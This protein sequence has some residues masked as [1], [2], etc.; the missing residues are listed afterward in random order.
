MDD[1]ADLATRLQRV[2]L[3]DAG[4]LGGKLLE[5]LQPLDVV[6]EALA[7]GARARSGDRI[8]RDQEDGLHGLRLD[9][10]VVRLDR[11]DDVLRLAVAARELG[12]DRRVRALDLVGHRLAEVVQHRRPLGHLHADLGGHDARE[13][14]DLERVLE[15]ILPI[16][17]A[18]PEAP[19]DL[20]E[21]LVELTAVRLEHGLFAGLDDVLLDL[22]LG[23]VVGVL[24]PGR[25]D[26]AVFDQLRERQLRDLAPDAVEGR[27]DD[28]LRCVVDDEVDAGQVL[29]RA[30]VASLAPDDPALHVVGRELDHGD[31]RLGG[32]A[33]GDPL[34]RVRDEV[35]C[36]AFRLDARLFFHL[37]DLARQLVPD[38]VLGAL[39]QVLFRLV[40][41]HACDALELGELL[42]LCLL[43]FVLELLEVRLTIGQA[44]LAT[45]EL[46]ELPVDLLLLREDALLDLD[47]S[48]AVVGDLSVDLRAQR[49]RLLARAD[50]GL[51]T[52]RLGLPLGVVDHLAAQLSRLA[53]A[54]LSDDPDRQKDGGP[55]EEESD[56]CPECDQHA[57]LLGRLSAEATA[58]ATRRRADRDVPNRGW[59]SRH[60]GSLKRSAR[61]PL[62]RVSRCRG[63][64]RGWTRVSGSQTRFGKTRCAGKSSDEPLHPSAAQGSVA[65]PVSRADSTASSA[66]PLAAR[67]LAVAGPCPRRTTIADARRG[68]GS[69]LAIASSISSVSRPLRWR[70][71]RIA[72]SP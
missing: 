32:V 20:D 34:Q 66:K 2:H 43:V 71:W 44:L 5:S 6:L 13:V 10:V 3:V 30:D 53:D 37:P 65:K 29:E 58:A 62:A 42:V 1:H 12:R 56:Q 63:C 39:E 31:G 4:L 69:N 68:S 72:A 59:A 8:G 15:D 52:D 54:G 26:P 64:G 57:R 33:R 21:L 22:G 18:I 50:L 25:V 36:A 27:E 14:D 60:R 11:M 35:A 40:R 41:G 47:D 28:G 67:C 49:D 70:S 24:D 16:A 23:L 61:R 51:A 38:E 55:S 48:G 9:L 19:E 17:R 46:G 7:P 45:R